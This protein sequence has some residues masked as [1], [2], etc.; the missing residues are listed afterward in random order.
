[1][2]KRAGASLTPQVLIHVT[3]LV[4]FTKSSS[5]HATKATRGVPIT[6]TASTR[7]ASTRDPLSELRTASRNP[8]PLPLPL[9]PDSHWCTPRAW[10]TDE[11]KRPNSTCDSTSNSRVH[12][13][14]CHPGPTRGPPPK[15]APAA[16]FAV[17]H[18]W[19]G[20]PACSEQG[21]LTTSRYLTRTKPG[22]ECEAKGPPARM[23]RTK[24]A[25]SPAELAFHGSLASKNM[26]TCSVVSVVFH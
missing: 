2:G 12:E 17:G 20:F 5:S 3:A 7:T 13:K 18:S 4:P 8:T 1:V 19:E 14:P 15:P 6:S 10:P 22:Q 21:L 25:L 24:P 9:S 26:S 23:A 16:A 11:L